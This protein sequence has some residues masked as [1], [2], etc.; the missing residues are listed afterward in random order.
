MKKNIPAPN[1][2]T[3]VA[4]ITSLLLLSVITLLVLALTTRQQLDIQ[5][6]THLAHVEQSHWYALSAENWARRLLNS[7]NQVVDSLND[8]WALSVTPLAIEQGT[9]AGSISDLQGRFNINNLLQNGKIH[10]LSR[11]RFQRLVTE[12]KIDDMFIPALID[13]LDPDST[14][15]TGGAEDRYYNTLQPPYRAANQLMT[16]ISELRLVRGVNQDIYAKLLPFVTA[17]PVPTEI[18]VNTAPAAIL[19]T[20]TDDN[21][22][23]VASVIHHR[24]QRAFSTVNHLK[25]YLK[26]AGANDPSALDGLGVS[27]HYFLVTTEVSLGVARQRHET[28][29]WRDKQGTVSLTRSPVYSP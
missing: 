22:L 13:W 8:N 5:R 28:L 24:E 16:D 9:V 23:D 3:G 29:L 7:D 21:G 19:Q 12:L 6:N 10:S 18:N 11:A 15:I 2:E 20:L 1:G 4:L 17:L 26:E 25:P 14:E 27:S